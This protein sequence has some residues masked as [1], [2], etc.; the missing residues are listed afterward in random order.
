MATPAHPRRFFQFGPFRLDALNRVLRRDGEIVP[1]SPA[2]METLR[3]L[4]E[5]RGHALTKEELLSAV[6]PDT[7]VE[8]SNL[9][10]N[11]SVLRK[12]L[13]EGPGEQR[14]IQTIPRR[15]YRFVA[16]VSEVGEMPSTEALAPEDAARSRLAVL[17]QPLARSAWVRR[18]A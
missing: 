14:F 16:A 18:F 10:H 4:V 17:P 7:F 3:V 1:L 2:I 9:A 5:N 12:T 6:W 15:G 13:G 11:I 8:E